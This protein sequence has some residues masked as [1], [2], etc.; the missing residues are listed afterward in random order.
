MINFNLITVN[1]E[2]TKIANSKMIDVREAEKLGMLYE[3]RNCLLD[4]LDKKD[5]CTPDKRQSEPKTGITAELNDIL[6]AL[7]E[8]QTAKAD[9]QQHKTTQD[10]VNHYLHR[11]VVEINDF[12][13]MLYANTTA[14]EEREILKDIKLLR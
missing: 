13:T 7:K 14:P 6:P 5:N 4:L 10:G 2:I 3:A 8:Y 1:A 11:L 9:F 12:L